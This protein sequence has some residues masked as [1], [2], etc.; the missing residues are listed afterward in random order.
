MH[1]FIRVSAIFFCCCSYNFLTT[2]KAQITIQPKTHTSNWR[3][4]VSQTEKKF[5]SWDVL[6]IS[7]S[8][9][10]MIHLFLFFMVASC[11]WVVL[12]KKWVTT[13]T[14]PAP[15]PDHVLQVCWKLSMKYSIWYLVLSPMRFEL[16]TPGLREQLSKIEVQ[17]IH[18]FFMGLT[19]FGT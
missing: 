11:Y 16:S 4:N 9:V 15:F 19:Y 10:L 12:I 8:C 18:S 2:K 3:Y 7:C 1:A 13:P 17:S 6:W 14:T 5:L